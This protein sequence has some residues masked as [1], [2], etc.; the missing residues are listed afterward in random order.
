M[1]MFMKPATNAVYITAY[2]VQESLKEVRIVISFVAYLRWV[3]KVNDVTKLAS[4]MLNISLILEKF[5]KY[6]DMIQQRLFYFLYL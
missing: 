4:M 1:M 3:F 2:A 5:L 6:F